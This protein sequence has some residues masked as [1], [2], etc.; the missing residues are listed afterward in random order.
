MT[1]SWDVSEGGGKNAGMETGGHG[2][3][4]GG[5]GGGVGG[6]LSSH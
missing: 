1:S 5:W 3:G 6:G 2:V 4:C